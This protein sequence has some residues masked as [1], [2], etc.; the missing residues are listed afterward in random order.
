[1]QAQKAEEELEAAKHGGFGKKKPKK[2]KRKRS[3]K[4]KKAEDTPFGRKTS[5]TSEDAGRSRSP[6]LEAAQDYTGKLVFSK[7]NEEEPECELNLSFSG[8]YVPNTD[9]SRVDKGL[10]NP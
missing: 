8:G 7:K 4:S 1:L 10:G 5:P 6:S 2:V 3:K 9:L